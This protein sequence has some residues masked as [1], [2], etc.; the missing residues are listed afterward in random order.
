MYP[1]PKEIKVKKVVG[2]TTSSQVFCKIKKE[3]ILVE[4]QRVGVFLEKTFL[5]KHVEAF[6]VIETVHLCI[7]GFKANVGNSS[8][9]N[10]G[11]V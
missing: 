9:Q 10:I 4:L 8:E 5:L 1:C 3:C 6:D 7:R 2:T 11:H